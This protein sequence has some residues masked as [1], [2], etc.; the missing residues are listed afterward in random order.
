[1]TMVPHFFDKSSWRPLQTENNNCEKMSRAPV[2]IKLDAKLETENVHKLFQFMH[3]RCFERRKFEMRKRSALEQIALGKWKNVNVDRRLAHDEDFALKAVKIDGR[4]LFI[5]KLV[6]TKAIVMAAIENRPKIQNWVKKEF[7][8]DPDIRET[9]LRDSFNYLK[10]PMPRTFFD[11]IGRERVLELVKKD[12]S[13]L[14]HFSHMWQD[15]EIVKEALQTYGEALIYTAPGDRELIKLALSTCSFISLY[16]FVNYFYDD[17][18]LLTLV[19]KKYPSLF[20]T[21]SPKLTSDRNFV[22]KL[23]SEGCR[24]S[25]YLSPELKTDMEIIENALMIE[26]NTELMRKITNKDTALR[27]IKKNHTMF[28]Y[29]IVQHDRELLLEILKDAPY[30]MLGNFNNDKEM[31]II[32]SKTH[33]NY[34]YFKDFGDDLKRDKDVIMSSVERHPSNTLKHALYQ[35]EDIV[36]EA[37]KL[38][39]SSLRFVK[40]E[41]LKRDL[42]LTAVKSDACAIFFVGK[43]FRQDVEIMMEVILQNLWDFLIDHPS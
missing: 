2:V 42:V 16:K 40:P 31:G 24:I 1:M 23:I 3:E 25:Y 37:V 27:I 17:P 22:L 19:L 12:G 9:V 39:C 15:R 34:C 29:S 26:H 41:L 20:S 13:L 21:G 4:S 14:R 38:D 5:F 43:E 18:E 6:Q 10:K 30:L 35:D 32:V 28:N 8:I 7:L 33:G 11:G 36:R